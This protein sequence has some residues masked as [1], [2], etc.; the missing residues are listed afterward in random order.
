MK[1]FSLVFVVIFFFALPSYALNK[2]FVEKK[3]ESV[4]AQIEQKKASYIKMRQQYSNLLFKIKK[5]DKNINYLKYRIKINK[6]GL[7]K[8]NKR[9]VSLKKDVGKV[10]IQLNSQKSRLKKEFL[11]YYKYSRIGSYYKQGV[12]Y[13]HMNIFIAAYMQ[14]KIK[15][16]IQKRKYLKKKLDTLNMYVKR[17]KR[18]IRKIQSQESDL[19][20]KMKE[21]SVLTA[22]AKKNK[23]SYLKDIKQLS[24]E[25]SRLQTILQKIIAEER[26]KQLEEEKKKAALKHSITIKPTSIINKYIVGKEFGALKSRI[27]PPVYGKVI[28]TFG[29]KYDTVFKVYTR[30]DGIDIKTKM[31]ACIKSIGTGKVDYIGNLPVYGGVIIINHLNGYY[32]VY[33]GIIPT[34][35]KNSAVK[36]YQCIG[37]VNGD[38]LHF[39]LRRHAQAVDPLKFLDRRYLR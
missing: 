20:K 9:I 7:T 8:L 38:R 21:L 1:K 36:A 26:K 6:K 35:R 17:K 16:Y 33:G 24:L 12:W 15:R 28:D 32:T 29:Q 31:G 10:S 39:E 34:V 23:E 14:N 25:Q 30:N 2:S 11:E 37:K 27:K 19:R 4:K 22:Q 5:M 3:I 18:I 13:E